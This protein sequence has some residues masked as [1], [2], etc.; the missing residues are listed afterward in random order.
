M[1]PAPEQNLQLA[2]PMEELH[3]SATSL[4]LRRFLL[5]LPKFWWVPVLTLALGIA[6]EVVYVFLKEPAFVSRAS[7]WQTLKLRLPEG[8]VFSDDMQNYMQSYAAT[9][10]G[11]LQ[12][13]TLQQ[14][15]IAILKA[16]TNSG[17]IKFGKDGEPL[18]VAIS[19]S[20]SAKSEMYLIQAVSMDPWFTRTYLDAV[21]Q[22][23]LD[24]MKTVR[25]QVSGETLAPLSDQMQKWEREL[26]AGQDALLA[27]ERTNNLAIVQEEAT[28]AGSYLTKLKTQLSDLQLEAHLLDAATNNPDLIP[29]GT[30]G[31]ISDTGSAPATG[32]ASQQQSS[33]NEIEILK[34]QR[35]K[36]SKYLR[37]KHPKIVKLDAD[38]EHA[39]QLQAIYHRQGREQLTAARQANQ[40]KT[41]NV[42]ASIQE[43]E[44]K[45]VEANATIS[46]A[47]RLK[48]DVQRTQ[49]VYD[50]LALL[51]QNVGISR[52]IDQESLAILEPAT[53]TKR[54]YSKEKTGLVLAILGGLAAGLGIVFLIAIRDDRFTSVTEVTSTLSD[55]VVGMLPEVGQ[56]EQ[57]VIP[58]LKLNDPRHVYA[59]SYRSL[60]SALLFQSTAG[61]ERPK[62]LLITSSMPGEGKS[63]VAANL[64]HTL[65]LSGSRVLLVDADLRRGHLHRLL[66]LQRAPGLAELLNQTCQPEQVMQKDPQLPLTFIGS[67]EINSGNPGDLFLISG[68]DQVLARWRQEFDYVLID[69]SPLFAADDASCLAP[70]VDGTLFVVRNQRSGARAAREAL[71]LLAQRQARV[72]GVVFNGAN[73][74]S[75]SYYYYKYADYHSPAPEK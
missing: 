67:G 5:F 35:E 31:G 59:E 33:R 17:S 13:K 18:P 66:G 48:L 45:V 27:Y 70:K 54:S 43:W 52:N 65:A 63:T 46:E 49:S 24:Y 29:S 61:G 12:S 32:A 36:L 51:V 73:T 19:V 55:P 28:V 62:L 74:T 11:F 20:G 15:A 72:L 75:R 42:V 44:A 47:E 4:R 68:L 53:P 23:Y 71:D 39:E 3:T 30:G 60:R 21:M 58:L 69:S 7:M 50:R 38:I 1:I 8:G 14:S 6:L 56:N 34:L 10:S 2:G 57:S 9:L 37:P 41:D 26:K 64:A 22:A 16:S 40:L 25:A